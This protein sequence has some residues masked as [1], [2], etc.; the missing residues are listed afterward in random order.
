MSLCGFILGEFIVPG[1]FKKAHELKEAIVK[2]GKK[3]SFREGTVW[4]RTSDGSI[5]KI[6]LYVPEKRFQRISAY[7]RS[8]MA[9]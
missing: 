2:K 7:S 5:V 6:G 4:L 3:F 9:L 8:A 1:V